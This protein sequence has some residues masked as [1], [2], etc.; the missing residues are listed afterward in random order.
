MKLSSF[1]SG[2]LPIALAIS[3]TGLA[4]AQSGLTARVSLN[5]SGAQAND[6]SSPPAISADGRYIVFR[7]F[8]S[9]LVQG[10]TNGMSDVFLRDRATGETSLMSVDSNGQLGDQGCDGGTAI[11]PDGR[12]VVFASFASNMVPGDTNTDLD[13]FVHDRVTGVTTRESVDANGN[14]G[15]GD[16][17]Y[18]SISA[19][20]RYVAFASTASNLVPGDSNFVWDVFVHDRLTGQTVRVSVDSNGQQSNGSSYG[21]VISFDG[22]LVGFTSLATNLVPGDTNNSRDAFVHDMVTGATTMI[23]VDSN[24]QPGNGDSVFTSFSGDARLAVFHGGA[25]NLVPGDTNFAW[26]VFVRDLVAGSTTRVSVDSGGAQANSSSTNGV[27]SS[28]GRYVAF[29]SQATNLVAG[30]TNNW[31]DVFVKDRSTGVVERVSVSA[32]GTQGD[33]WSDAPVIA[34]GGRLIAFTSASTNLVSGD[35]NGFIDVFVRDRNPSGFTSVCDP[36]LAG[37]I[38]CPC[39]NAPSGS[40]RGCDNSSATGGASITAAGIAYLSSDSLV[41]TTSGEKPSATSILL[42]GTTSPPA[43]AVYGQGVRCV[44]GTTKRLFTKTAVAGS[45]TA[46]D[47]GAGDPTVSARSAAKGNPISAG[48]SRWYLVF[49]RDPTVVG[50]CPA[51]STFNATQTGRVDWSL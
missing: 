40:G 32:N 35:T 7:S 45:I 2:V 51:T 28:D 9:T 8:A 33:M 12:Y 19:D 25:S 49:Y 6:D 31:L 21:P 48:Q 13:V 39:S 18:P 42:Q 37:V 44:G 23:S 41:F 34:A 10:D 47:F 26:D 15:N 46:P 22:R 4:S 29:S 30:D 1:S 36:G 20:G 17:R 27:I 43:G 11:T 5:S 16:S 24:G 50:G 14:Q 3:V 38:A